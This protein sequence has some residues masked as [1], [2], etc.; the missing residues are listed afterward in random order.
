MAAWKW[1][2][3]AALRL[4]NE[5]DDGEAAAPT[6]EAA[7]SSIC[8]PPTCHVAACRLPA[9]SAATG[10]PVVCSADLTS[11]TLQSGWIDSSRAADPATWGQAI[12]VPCR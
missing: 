1:S 11:W 6:L 8:P 3:V 5:S 7:R 12:D 2:W 10:R 4:P 9:S